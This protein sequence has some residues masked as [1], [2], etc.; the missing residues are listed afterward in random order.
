MQI[1]QTDWT[2]AITPR[3][4]ARCV[5]VRH[6]KFSSGLPKQFG[7]VVLSM[8]V[9]DYAFDTLAAHY[10][11]HFTYTKIGGLLRQAI[12]RRFDINFHPG[13]RVL[14]LNCGTGED[15][16]YLGRRGVQVLATDSSRAMI[17]STRQK[18]ARAGLDDMVQ[19]QQLAWEGLEELD[20]PPFDGALSNF[21]GLNCVADLAGVARTLARR[22][23][24]GANTLLCV[25][26]PLAPW[27][28]GWFLARGQ[29]AL[30]FRRLRPGGVAWRGLMIHYPSIHKLRRAF[31]PLFHPQRVSAV[32]VLLPPP[33]AEGWAAKHPRLLERLNRWERRVETWPPLPWLADH[34]LLEL[35]RMWDSKPRRHLQ[36]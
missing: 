11:D 24:P 20:A 22:L 19:V 7:E 31:Q 4:V 29:L 26:G 25:M 15:A 9:S 27:E 33:Y 23:Q 8:G 12:W 21:G 2:S 16:V 34:Y 18:V 35:E 36:P 28:L 30:A 32:G 6:T 14:E 17:E 5:G 1:Q 10:D 13:S 3:L